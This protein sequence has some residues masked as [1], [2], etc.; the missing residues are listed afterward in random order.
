[1]MCDINSASLFPFPVILSS[2]LHIIMG[3]L[4]NIYTLRRFLSYERVHSRNILHTYIA[5]GIFQYSAVV[6]LVCVCV[7][8]VCALCFFFASSIF[9]CT[10]SQIR[11]LWTWLSSLFFHLEQSVG[12][13]GVAGTWPQFPNLFS[14][15]AVGMSGVKMVCG[16]SLD[17]N[18]NDSLE[19]GFHSSDIS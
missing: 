1:M 5:L 8:T 18:S 6:Y 11:C 17:K 12:E 9:S 7:L 15:C 4:T 13:R 14:P 2:W 10:F 19:V 16:L 3:L